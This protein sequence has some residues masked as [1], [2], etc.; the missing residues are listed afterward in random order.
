MREQWQARIII[1]DAHCK[2]TPYI[3]RDLDTWR[4]ERLEQLKAS[5]QREIENELSIWST[6]YRLKSKARVNPPAPS[7]QPSR[8]GSA[9]GKRDL[10][11]ISDVGSDA[12]MSDN[13]SP[14]PPS[15][16]GTCGGERT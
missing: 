2:M 10:A 16:P 7:K 9:F 3:D 6:Q 12:D 11:H 4:A 15:R 14:S 1:A 13:L 8:P 5:V